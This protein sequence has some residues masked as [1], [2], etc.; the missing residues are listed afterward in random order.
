MNAN[1]IYEERIYSRW[2][3]TALVIV[4]CILF[5]MLI[6]QHLVGPVGTRP[7]PDWILL[8]I[9]LLLLAVMVNFATLTIRLTQ[10]G[11]SVGY[12]IIRHNI[13]WSNVSDCYQ[14]KASAVWYGGFGVRLGL[15]N[16]KWRLV[17]N[18]I[19][20]PRVVIRKRQ[21]QVQEFVFSTNNPDEVMRR[22]KERIG[23]RG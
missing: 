22:I 3:T 18:T 16:G 9:A 20:N 6:Y 17:Y 2:L 7:A 8:A 13:P 1:A 10:S 11:I 19:G 12:G 14:D 15:V 4:A 23:V 21:G 5:G